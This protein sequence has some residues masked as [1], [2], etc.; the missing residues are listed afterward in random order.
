LRKHYTTL[1]VK[2]IDT[3]KA[4]YVNTTA[5][6]ITSDGETKTFELKLLQGDTFAPFLF[7]VALDYILRIS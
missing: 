3:I 6:I 5:S 1:R 2:V 4:L 7:I